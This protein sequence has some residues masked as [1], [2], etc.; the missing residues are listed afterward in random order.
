MFIKFLIN[1]VHHC[2]IDVS[3]SLEFIVLRDW[4]FETME[5][6][7]S[8]YHITLDR[9]KFYNELVKLLTD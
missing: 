6:R 1:C 9:S 4:E 7:E 5:R 2:S 8:Y 3:L